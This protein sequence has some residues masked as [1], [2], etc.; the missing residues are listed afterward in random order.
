MDYQL[1]TGTIVGVIGAGSMGGGIAQVAA[2]SGHR[3]RLLDAH[4]GA[5]TKAIERIAADLAGGVQRRRIEEHQRDTMLAAITAVDTLDAL[6]GCGLVIEAVAEDL[7]AKQ[8]LFREVEHVVSSRTVLATNT[9]SISITAIAQGLQHPQRLVGWHF[10]NPAPRMKLV[11]I[12][13]G[14]ETDP[15]LAA[16]M[17][18]L[19]RAWGKTPV[20]APNTAGFI[21]NRVARPYYGEA[22]RLLAEGLATVSAIDRLLTEAGGFALGPFELIDLIGVDVN[23]AVTDSVFEAT[24]WDARYAPHPIQQ[25]LVR[26]GH[27]GRKSGRGFYDYRDKAER[28]LAALAPKGPRPEKVVIEGDLGVA[29]PLVELAR[30]A[31]LTVET[32]D[33]DGII[34]IDGV[35][36]MLTDGRTATERAT[37]GEVRTVLFDLALDYAAASRMALAA[38]DQDGS[39]A[40]AAAA[41]FFQALGKSVSIIDDAPGLIVMRTVAMLANEAADAV[42]HGVGTAEDVDLAML[43]GVNYPR[44][45]LV[46][47]ETVGLSKIV[48][49]MDNLADAYGEDRY[50]T[51]PLLRR[52]ALAAR[53]FHSF[54]GS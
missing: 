1:D 2:A 36:L 47:A 13:R 19:S 3:V 17:R 29:G 39:D 8:S 28:P 15:L 53:S 22:L 20:S 54:T 52:R 6:E 11:E 24:Q 50:R 45:P 12:V 9:S 10:F 23:Q 7:G 38:A 43:K 21:V 32:G 25:E 27:Y 30:S 16:L 48:A 14:L 42:H 34:R 41:G 37:D 18:T 46:W 35:R 33:G 49:V 31:G 51:S 5:T 40:I 4:P 26:A 44:G